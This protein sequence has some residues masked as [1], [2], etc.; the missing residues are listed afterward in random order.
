M[1]E[2]RCR[3][4]SRQIAAIRAIGWITPGAVGQHV[5]AGKLIPLAVA[6]RQRTK[7][8][9]NVPTLVELGYKDIAV[10]E[11]LGWYAPARVSRELVQKLNAAVQDALQ[12]PEMQEVFTRNGLLADDEF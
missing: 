11:Y 7:L 8:M 1:G 4:L 10:V 9:P 5:A 3:V 12:T 2:T 6:E